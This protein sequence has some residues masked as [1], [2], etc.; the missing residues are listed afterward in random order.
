MTKQ[1]AKIKSE[2]VQLSLMPETP[3]EPP[4]RPTGRAS[5]ASKAT[6]APSVL[7]APVQPSKRP[8]GRPPKG[9]KAMTHAERQAAYRLRQR[10]TVAAAACEPKDQP[11]GVILDALG[12]LL[13]NLDNPQK[14]DIHASERWAAARAVRELCK[15][16]GLKPFSS[17]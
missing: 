2:Q 17:R 13:R 4:Q 6:A 8:T 15:R 11:T 16:Y 1:A 5:K 10:Q 3:T 9:V 7:E 12:L 14:A